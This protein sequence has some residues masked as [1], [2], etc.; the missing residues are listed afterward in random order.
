MRRRDNLD[1]VLVLSYTEF[2]TTRPRPGSCVKNGYTA[3]YDLAPLWGR[4]AMRPSCS[5]RLAGIYLVP[6]PWLTMPSWPAV[7]QMTKGGLTALAAPPDFLALGKVAA[8]VQERYAQVLWIRLQ[9]ADAD[10]GALLVTLL[11]AARRLDAE[12]SHG[13]AEDV[14]RH[15]R[16]GEWPIGYQLLADWLVAATVPPAVL[17]LE[18]AEH[19]EA[20]NPASLDMLVSAFLPHLQGS[21]NVL[22]IGFTEWD[23]R[24]L[25]PHGEV[26]GWSRLRLDRNAVTLL[27]ETLI[28]SLAAA[29]VDRSFALTHGAAGALQAAFSAGA[30]LGPEVFCATMAG[31]RDAQALLCALGRH[32]LE[33]ADRNALISLAVASRL[34]V[35]HPAM[36]STLGMSTLN[37]NEPWWLDL[38]EG[39]QQLSPAWRAPLLAAGGTRDIDPA[40]L[41]LL[42]DYISSQG[43]GNRAFELYMEAKEIDRATDIAVDLA[44]DLASTGSW[45]TLARLGQT[46]AHDCPVGGRIPEPPDIAE[47]SAPWW[48]RLACLA[49]QSSGWTGHAPRP[50]P[51]LTAETRVTRPSPVLIPS[52]AFPDAHRPEPRLRSALMRTTA[53]K[54]TPDLTAHLLG[55]LRV[56]FQDRPVE[57]WSSGRGRAVFEYLLVNHHGKVRRDRLMSI[58]WPEVSSDA[59]RN[60]LNVAIHG[61]RQSLRAAVGD[62]PVVIH[63]DQAYFI[64]PTLDIW[65]DVEVFE[66]HL[67]A[68]HQHLASAELAKAEAAFEAATWLYQGEFLADDPYEGWAMVIR[69]HLRLC[70]L[71]ALDRLGALHLDSGNYV[72]CVAVC[73]KL[74]AHDSCREDAHCRLM[75]CYSRQGQVQLAVR[76]YHSCTAALRTELD[77]APALATTEL[78]YRLRR[79]E[80]I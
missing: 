53:S 60:S 72:G 33:R 6:C 9:I 41:T 73:L 76:Q 40:S 8:V 54:A 27:G 23:P 46:L 28:P 17:V 39:W 68:A 24:R 32:L 57:I 15:A 14:A 56:A 36:A 11:G 31:A 35:W 79:R 69:E 48:R 25:D 80:A 64:E 34:G 74:L 42:A 7:E 50:Q 52:W 12:A 75:R 18:G 51:V 3:E 55:E 38:A 21:L 45:V 2:V 20:G 19:L 13:I 58:F 43:A 65:V 71:D 61:L 10:P 77:V 67:K 4:A 70:Y 62:I 1:R 59:A 78:F 30:V 49:R 26:L 37:R 5:E 16:H 29:T 63:Q 66:E 22:L 47:H 44:C